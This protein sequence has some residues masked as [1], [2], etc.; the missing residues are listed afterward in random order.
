MDSKLIDT[1]K[2]AALRRDRTIEGETGLWMK[3]TDSEARLL[4]LAATDA[5]P[6]Y[7]ELFPK[8]QAELRRLEGVGAEKEELAAV[9][10]RYYARMFVRDWKNVPAPDGSAAPFSQEA[11]AQFLAFADD[12]IQD[13]AVTCFEHRNFRMARAKETVEDVKN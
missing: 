5:N 11:A 1:T 4:V 6:A 9:R 13:L 2:F 7:V 8:M 10:A 3:I 12:A